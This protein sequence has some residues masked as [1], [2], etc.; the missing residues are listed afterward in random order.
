MGAGSGHVSDAARLA[1]AAVGVE[2]TLADGL[3]ESQGSA[4]SLDGLHVPG[5]V[6]VEALVGLVVA[7]EGQGG[8]QTHNGVHLAVGVLASISGHMSA[9]AVANEVQVVEGHAAVLLQEVGHGSHLLAG[10]GD[11]HHG[12]GV[13]HGTGTGPVNDDDVVVTLGQPGV[14]DVLVH[15]VQVALSPA[16]DHEPSGM[17]GIEVGGVDRLG[18]GLNALAL[19]GVG[20]GVQVEVNGDGGQAA[21]LHALLGL[22][23]LLGNIHVHPFEGAV[24]LGN[25]PAILPIDALGFLQSISGS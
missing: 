20:L 25:V 4:V 21:I 8:V 13:V 24:L 9:Q 16:V 12:G 14:A 11:G 10:L 18:G 5:V 1:L 7:E 19:G 6:G 2:G 17:S 15:A 3:Q 23:P 22:H